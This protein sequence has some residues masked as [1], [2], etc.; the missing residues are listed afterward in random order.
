MDPR[1]RPDHR[2]QT[3]DLHAKLVE[4]LQTLKYLEYELRNRTA[5]DAKERTRARAAFTA[6]KRLQDALEELEEAARQ[7]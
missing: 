2:E 3:G 5:Q 4:Y 7:N 6:L 1:K